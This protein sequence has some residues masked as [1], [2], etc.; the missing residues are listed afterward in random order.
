MRAGEFLT[1]EWRRLAML[2][3]QVDPAIL[4]PFVP[5]GVELDTWDNRHYVSVVGFLFL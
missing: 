2:N 4:R 3:Y 5:R 1:A